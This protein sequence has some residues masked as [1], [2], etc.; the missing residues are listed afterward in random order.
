MDLFFT[1]IIE[2][3]KLCLDPILLLIILVGVIWGNIAGALPGIGPSLAVGVV[4]PFTFGMTS[5]NAIAF[6]VAINV[7]CSYGNSIPA[8]L[9]GVPGTT[10]AVLT[11]IDGYEL[12][13]K[14]KS[15]LALGVQFY[16]AILGQFLSNFFFF[17]TVVPLAQLTYILLSPEMFALYF[18]GI[19]AVIGITGDNIVKGLMAAAF[20]FAITMVGRDPVSAVTRYSYFIEIT[21]GL[22]V[23]P[24]IIGLLAVSEL[25]RQTRQSFNWGGAGQK[26][27][28]KFPPWK[29]LW[30]MTPKVLLGCGIG[31]VV[32]A[33]P[34]LGGA[35]AAFISYTQAKMWSKHPELFGH[36]SIEGIA[37]NE[38]AQNASQA[39]EMVPTFGLG[40]PGSNTM[41]LLFA[42][43]IM[44]GF[45]PGPMLITQAPQLFYSAGAG[46]W[47]T[48][49]MLA[50][51]GWP[52]CMIL[53]KIVTLDRT[54]IIVGAL[55]LCMLGVWTIN[56]STFDVF[57]MLFFGVIGYFMM[58]YGYPVAAASITI[59]LGRGFEAY[60]RRGLV[61]TDGSWWAFLSRPWTAL[62][63]SISIALLIYGTIGTIR[64]ARKAAEIKKQRVADHL[65]KISG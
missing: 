10:S 27:S 65:T 9:V 64:L 15:G 42:A 59:V 57:V 48:T 19:S 6:L 35:Q 62:I 4:L 20:G 17:A 60:L 50:L 22:E 43:L 41:V 2:S 46:L 11:A 21:R 36:G 29:T 13:K 44:H 24:V 63:L 40:I 56:G 38:S 49:F 31:A 25:F 33:I 45:Y 16:A 28:A 8:I 55:G 47:A 18:L 54:A 23:T 61:I 37:A 51:M 53:Y 32:G 52:L 14:G 39:G 1:A 7:A 5:V 34:G 26:I 30:G 3:S 12:H 58:R